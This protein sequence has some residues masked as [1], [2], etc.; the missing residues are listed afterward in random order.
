MPMQD[1]AVIGITGRIGKRVAG[2]LL[3]RGAGSGAAT[4][5]RSGSGPFWSPLA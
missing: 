3:A 4:A 1:I 5:G 2:E